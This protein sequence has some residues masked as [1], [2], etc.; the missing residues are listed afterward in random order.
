MRKLL[1]VGAPFRA[2]IHLNLPIRAILLT[3]AGPRAYNG[4]MRLFMRAMIFG[5]LLSIGWLASAVA[6]ELSLT[7]VIRATLMFKEEANPPS[8]YPHLLKVYLCLDNRHDSDIQW[9]SDSVANVE[10]EL[11]DSKGKPVATTLGFAS[12]ISNDANYL[13]PYGSRLEWMISH[14]GLSQG[15]LSVG[16]DMKDH[17]VL[18]I[19][20]Q[21]WLIP[22]D[23]VSSYSLRIRVKGTPWGHVRTPGSERVLFDVPATRIEIK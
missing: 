22:I 7:N 17:Y 9:I 10:A 14:G 20:G 21:G 6:D 5:L 4:D 3:A 23:A 13:L 1:G 18:I 8:H 12:I 19:G 16:G 15:I 2:R 11:V